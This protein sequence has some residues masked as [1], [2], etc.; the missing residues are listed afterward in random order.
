MTPPIQ[1]VSS[2]RNEPSPPIPVLHDR[3]VKRGGQMMM[4]GIILRSAFKALMANKMRSIL[5]MLGIIIGIAAVIA[6]LSMGKGAQQKV[7]AQFTSM[8]T[9]LLFV[10]PAQK[11]IAGASTGTVQT[12]TLEDVTAIEQLPGVSAASPLIQGSMQLKYQDSNKRARVNGV[13]VSYFG[14][15]NFI[16]E[17][18]RA[19]T[20]FELEKAK[21]VIVLGPSLAATLFGTE[22]PI[23]EDEPK[24]IKVNGRDY[25][26]IG[27]TKAKGD[28]G[29]N[30]P[31]DQAIIPHTTAKKDISN[32]DYLN[33]IDIAVA[34]GFDIDQVSGQPPGTS[35]FGPPGQRGGTLHQKEPPA[36]SITA[37][38]RKRHR[39]QSLMD[40]D[41]FTMMSQAELL[42]NVS[43]TVASFR[44]LLG[45]V[46]LISLFVGGIG[47]MN[48]M[49]V[50]VTERTREIGVRK[51][52]GAKFKDIML[53][54]IVEAVM[55]TGMGG[56][57]GA[58]LGVGSS[59]LMAW[60]IKPT[61]P[62]PA[63]VVDPF[64]VVISVGV[65][66]VVGMVA[67]IYPAF[68]AAQLDPIEAL[69]YE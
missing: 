42:A 46:A 67:G 43:A 11:S 31:D 51:A 6:M 58:V 28:T 10:R 35:T 61:S 26:V 40:A 34:D 49:L 12:L 39:L 68:K 59:W 41:D 4:W 37:L 44:F 13:S 63:P 62:L 17:K 20:Q 55:M 38:L 30:N 23:D 8:G 9:N 65:S 52:I 18:G 16:I 19:F 69:R 45:G 50:T 5:A 53:Q 7:T 33:E 36:D 25:Y 3:P 56:I 57:L 2:R 27:V 21:R 64:Y 32:L 15:R 66:A 48:I 29:F 24:T 22:N 47:I 14:M 54:F 1:P 60:L